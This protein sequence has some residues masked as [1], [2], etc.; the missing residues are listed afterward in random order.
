MHIYKRMLEAAGILRA[1]EGMSGFGGGDSGQGGQSGSEG[2]DANGSGAGGDEDGFDISD[3]VGDDVEPSND[4][5]DLL[6]GFGGADED[7][8]DDDGA[9]DDE[10]ESFT[11]V[12]QEEVQA[13]NT[14]L[15][16]AIANMKVTPDMIPEDFDPTDR[17]Q[18]AGLMSKLM[19]STITQSLGVVFQPMQLAIKQMVSGTKAEI[20]KRIA[21]S[22]SSNNANN[23][24]LQEVPE[25]NDPR[26][27]KILQPMNAAM[28]EAG[29]KP[30]ERAQLMRKMLNQMGIKKG[31][32]GNGQNRQASG[33]GATQKRTGTAALDKFFGEM[34]KF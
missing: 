20:D 6:K 28:T 27:R 13:L 18:M 14:K 22:N 15:T 11:D 5:K 16:T 3:L 21:A 32:G 24:I 19:Q 33:E 23:I 34:P 29:K 30:K 12:S 26:L 2:N 10:G 17:A 31:A 4:L 8:D 9:G 25:Y 7:D 1:P